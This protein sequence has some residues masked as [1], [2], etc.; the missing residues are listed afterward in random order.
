MDKQRVVVTKPTITGREIL[1]EVGKTPEGFKLYQHKCGHQ[2]IQIGPNEVVN[3]REPGVERF[4]TMPKDTTEGLGGP[5]PRRQFKLPAPDHDYLDGLGLPWET[6]VDGQSNWLLI[7]EWQLPHGYNHEKTSL[8]LLIPGNYADS[9]IDMV[10]FNAHLARLDGHFIN[11]LSTQT[12][13]GEVWQRWSRHRTNQN[14]WRAGIDD[15]A[16][17]LALV[18]EWLRREFFRAAA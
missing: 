3:L 18:D 13:A 1:A 16:S 11:N 9:Q 15:I 7:H 12:I 4:S 8:A 10:Y 5:P 2:P 17:H 14:P 6:I